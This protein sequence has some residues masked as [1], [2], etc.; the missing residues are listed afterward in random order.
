MLQYAG[1]LPGLSL[2]VGQIVDT[3]DGRLSYK[4]DS[5]PGSGGG[6]LFNLNWRVIGMHALA[7]P[8]YKTN[9][10]LTISEL[11]D[12]LRDTPV[13][14]DIVAFHKLADLSVTPTPPAVARSLSANQSGAE[15]NLLRA[16]VFWDVDPAEFTADELKKLKPL[17]ANPS[18]KRL[19]LKTEERQRLLESAPSLAVL[20]QARG[21]TPPTD[22]RQAVIDRILQGG[23]FDFSAIAETDLP[24]WLQAV[25]W[26]A[27]V[28]PDLPTPKAINRTLQRRRVRS[29]FNPIVEDFQGRTAE[30]AKISSW[31]NNPKAGPMVVTGIGGVGKSSLVA[32]FALSLPA[33]TLLLWLDF[34]RA[35]LAPDNARS[36]LTQLIQQ[37]SV[38]IDD[39]ANL[40]LPPPAQQEKGTGLV[41]LAKQATK[42]EQLAA[43]RVGAELARHMNGAVPP[44]LVLDGFE[45]AQHAEHH[46]KI[47]NVL[48]SVLEKLPALRVIVSGRAE[49]S[50]LRLAGRKARSMHLTGIPRSDAK[51]WLHKQGITDE[52]KLEQLLDMAD[53]VPLNL[54]F[55]V[56]LAEAGDD[57]ADLPKL[58]QEMNS[59][60]L[61]NRILIRVLDPEIRDTNLVADVLVL[62]RIT[63]DL[64]GAVVPER[65][66]LGLTP[67]EVFDRLKNAL[68]LVDTQS[69][70]TNLT[71]NTSGNT[72]K[73][74]WL[75]PELRIGT[76][77][78]LETAD[79]NRVRG[80]DER[81]A[82]WYAQ[83]DS[84]NS[85]YAAELVYHR[86]RLGDIPGAETAWSNDC[87]KF[88]QRAEENLY[89]TATE[90]RQWLRKQLK[91][92]N[93]KAHKLSVW[94]QEA[95]E[96]IQDKLSRAL[97]SDLAYVLG[98]RKGRSKP[99]PLVF[100]DAW[101]RYST[102]D[103]EGARRLLKNADK[104]E[105]PAGRDQT[106][107][108]ALLARQCGEYP[109]ADRLLAR[110]NDESHWADRPEGNR[111]AL[112]VRAARV[113]LTVDMADELALI[114]LLQNQPFDHNLSKW[115]RPSD[116]VL[117][118]LQSLLPGENI[119]Q[120]SVYRNDQLTISA[121]V[122]DLQPFRK[123]LET[124]ERRTLNSQ[125]IKQVLSSDISASLSLSVKLP[126]WASKLMATFDEE[127]SEEVVKLLA[128]LAVL[129]QQRKQR[130]TEN[131]WLNQAVLELNNSALGSN[132]LGLS[133]G[134]SL[135]GVSGLNLALAERYYWQQP[136]TK[137]PQSQFVVNLNDL[138]RIAGYQYFT[139]FT[140]FSTPARFAQ[141][142]AIVGMCDDNEAVMD[143][144]ATLK[145]AKKHQYA[146]ELAPLPRSQNIDIA[147]Q[148][149]RMNLLGPVLYLL[150][151]DPLEMLCERL[152]F[153]PNSYRF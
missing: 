28:V 99:S 47:W 153:L 78:L 122:D 127:P 27:N 3:K 74:F 67:D 61:N 72:E 23:D 37:A 142:E 144:L 25:R 22:A 55:V 87:I 39:F 84:E 113:R 141:V 130:I 125:W 124:L 98:E 150:G 89:P 116:V 105:G 4:A 135:T 83:Q 8:E 14:P 12:G 147:T 92:A 138:I 53:G 121:S 16:A 52:S 88:L 41:E 76:L 79:A 70:F 117:P 59:A 9:Q 80:I 24:Y 33:K 60:Y 66:P 73:A 129:S 119:Y 82:H 18:A 11:L 49:V 62:R 58:Q 86:L 7:D 57:F 44:L 85:I 151:P 115:L 100:Y 109:E 26:F 90:E 152:L 143:W 148:L 45:V 42:Q 46:N 19:T 131:L 32:R 63:P 110:I 54:K 96:R 97:H 35:D 118:Q 108:A 65:L 103:V 134:L 128:T 43:E 68:D 133:I 139:R 21:K 15:S 111:E 104:T 75:R 146:T 5:L 36:V 120:S 112:A 114:A 64:I 69:I 30:L 38:Q 123:Q 56:R 71:G 132:P 102:G 10:G 101:L 2:A 126:S 29:Q 136:D 149:D 48:K 34:D 95:A 137:Y 13:W 93:T 77:R 6:A 1:S 94:E 20:Q 107:L 17:V 50:G 81:A 145:Q 140:D 51:T 91:A 106:V 31:F 40:E